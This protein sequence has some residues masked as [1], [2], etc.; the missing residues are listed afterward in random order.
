MTH[1]PDYYGIANTESFVLQ[2]T[3]SITLGLTKADRLR[4]NES[5]MTHAMV[6][7]G[8]HLDKDGKPVRYKVEN[9]WGENSG[10][11]GYF[12]MSD[13]WFDE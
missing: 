3:F 2:N 12:V 11:K 1:H 5:S 10:N 7:S 4:V 6:I 8:V 9:S 13:K